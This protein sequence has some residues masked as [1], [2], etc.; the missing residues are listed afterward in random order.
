[1]ADQPG[2]LAS[3]TQVLGEQDVSIKSV[4]QRGMGEHA[5]LVMVT[6]PVLESRLRAAIGAIGE[7]DFV[8][9]DAAH[10]SRDRRGVRMSQTP[11]VSELPPVPLPRVEGAAFSGTHVPLIE[12][13]HERLPFEP[14]DQLVSLQEGS[15]PLLRA[16]VLSRDRRRDGAAE[17]RGR[18][19]DRLVQGSRHDLR[20]LGGRARR[21]QGGDLRLDR[22]HRGERRRLRGARRH[23][24]RGDRARGQDRAGQDGADARARR[25]RDLAGAATSTRR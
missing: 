22:Q 21:R 3:V 1:M 9:S 15:T 2:V 12:R 23:H 25:A 19:P 14:G 17:A 6:H 10:D 4:V 11:P 5:R 13:Y 7:F 18:Q 16:P 24:L 20:G 8:R